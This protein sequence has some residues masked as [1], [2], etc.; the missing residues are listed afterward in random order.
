MSSSKGKEIVTCSRGF[1]YLPRASEA[2][3]SPLGTI[4]AESDDVV[5]EL[6]ARGS[7]HHHNARV[8][9][10][11]LRNRHRSLVASTS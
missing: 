9:L 4:T 7:W 1:C 8:M 2:M 5:L 3:I 11:S 10:R 6:L